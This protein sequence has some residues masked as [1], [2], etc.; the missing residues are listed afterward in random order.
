MNFH[1]RFLFILRN[2]L[3]L[4]KIVN[5]NQNEYVKRLGNGQA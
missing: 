4:I 1:D 5:F 3:D 2:F